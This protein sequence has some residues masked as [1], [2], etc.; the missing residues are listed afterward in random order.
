MAKMPSIIKAFCK[1]CRKH[2][3]HEV[4]K[5]KPGRKRRQMSK[6]ER[7]GKRHKKG[8]GN[9]GRYSKRAITQTSRASKTSKKVDLKLVCKEC[10][11]AFSRGYPRTKKF[12]IVR[13]L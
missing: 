5:V 1:S 8:Y 13:A 11:K 12:E 4:K 3:D 10:G 2:N 9:K 6:G 7:R